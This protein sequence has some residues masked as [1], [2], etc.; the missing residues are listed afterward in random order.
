MPGLM[1]NRFLSALVYPLYVML[2]GLLSMELGA[3][4]LLEDIDSA[5]SIRQAA[6]PRL[7]NSA[8]TGG[9]DAPLGIRLSAN[10]EHTVNWDE[11]SYTVRTNSLGF[12]GREVAPRGKNEHRILFLGDSMVFGHGLDEEE[13]VPRQVERLAASSE[14]DV[15]AYNGA[16]SGMNTVQE[17]AAARQLL[18]LLQPDQ[19]VLG[20]FVGNDPLANTFCAIGDDGGVKFSEQLTAELHERLDSHLRSLL[21]SVAFRAVA[22]RYYVPR[23]RYV[24]SAEDE[25]LE[26]S[27]QLIVQIRDACAAFGA[28]FS[29]LIIYPRDAVADGLTSMFSGSRGVGQSLS[30]RLADVD[31]PVLDSVDY[32]NVDDADE[33]FYFSHDGHLNAEGAQAVAMGITA[34]LNE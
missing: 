11:F 34:D 25:T 18:P 33:Q 5:A 14:V 15:V 27:T 3:R 2:F 21:P 22:L 29:V 6:L 20:Y 4:W 32:L 16:I 19:V 8:V 13:T 31:V 12:R 9:G 17:L 28:N 10:T 26:R 30:V 23:L 1:R 24:W 7:L